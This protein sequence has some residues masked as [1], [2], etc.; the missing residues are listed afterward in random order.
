[1]R[2]QKFIALVGGTAV[3]PLA[4][5]AQQPK[6]MRRI[7]VLMSSADDPEFRTRLAAFQQ[8]LQQLG[9]TDGRNVRVDARWSVGNADDIRKHA[10]EL[11]A[12]APDVILTTSA[13]TVAALVLVRAKVSDDKDNQ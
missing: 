13:P 3:W 4:A 10:A 11:V 8:S 2:R 7:G 9:W 6:A 1:M 5:R 12:L